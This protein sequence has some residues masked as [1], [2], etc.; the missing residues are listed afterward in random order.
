MTSEIC[1]ITPEA[2]T[3]RRRDHALLDARAAALV[4]ADDGAAVLHG[5][6]EDL[7][8]LL[9]V[10]LAETAPEH[11]DVLGEDGDRPA[12]D[13]A[14]PGDDAVA[15]RAL[16]LHPEVRGPVAGELV[17]LGERALVQQRLEPLAGRHL[18][19]GVLPLDRPFGSCVRRLL[20]PAFEIGQLAGG[21]VDVDVVGDVLPRVL[22]FGRGHGP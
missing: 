15:E 4:D 7:D 17:E 16:L 21:G 20:H 12:V 8:D 2:S 19:R 22:E 11:G 14:V 3:L 9:A 18:A 13:G 6:V 1:G 10:D 5:E